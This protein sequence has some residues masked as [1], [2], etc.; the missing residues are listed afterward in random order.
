M[1]SHTWVTLDIELL[2]LCLLYIFLVCYPTVSRMS[3][4]SNNSRGWRH[5]SMS[6]AIDVSHSTQQT[7]PDLLFRSDLFVGLFTLFHECD[8]MCGG[9]TIL[10]LTVPHT[11][12]TSVF[13]LTKCLSLSHN[14]KVKIKNHEVYQQT[15]VAKWPNWD[16]SLFQCD[17]TLFFEK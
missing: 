8:V 16:S 5:F 9:V 17:F 13:E 4:L 6:S 14:C 2:I 7:K 10:L 3:R 15:S 12:E 11:T 1:L